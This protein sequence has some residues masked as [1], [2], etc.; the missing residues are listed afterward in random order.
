MLDLRR[1]NLE[2][3]FAHQ[4]GLMATRQP[5]PTIA[6]LPASRGT[7]ASGIRWRPYIMRCRRK[8]GLTAAKHAERVERRRALTE[9]WLMRRHLARDR[10][11]IAPDENRIIPTH[12]RRRGP[13]SRHELYQWHMANGTLHVF[14]QMFRNG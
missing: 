4:F 2:R 10:R 7:G 3:T 6:A 12:P 13:M 8:P 1:H 11:Q 5:P 9:E 14:F